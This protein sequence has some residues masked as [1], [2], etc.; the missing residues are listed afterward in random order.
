MVFMSCL[1]ELVNIQLVKKY[2]TEDAWQSIGNIYFIKEESSVY[3]C[4]SIMC[5]SCLQ[6]QN[7]SRAR[8]KNTPINQCTSS[9]SHVNTLIVNML[10]HV[11]KISWTPLAYVHV[12][13]H[14]YIVA[15]CMI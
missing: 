1:D 6:W 7:F 2:R 3:I 10:P 11:H 8:L 4:N 14:L 13:W 15:I 12:F 5:S 9:V